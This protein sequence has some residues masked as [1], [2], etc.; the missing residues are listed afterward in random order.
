MAITAACVRTW[1]FF[2]PKSDDLS[3]AR[4]YHNRPYVLLQRHHAY[5]GRDNESQAGRADETEQPPA[6][7]I[8]S[9]VQRTIKVSGGHSLEHDHSERVIAETAAGSLFYGPDKTSRGWREIGSP[10]REIV[11]FA[12]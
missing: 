10:R 2:D 8:H 9:V 5:L 11:K 7:G 6:R 4:G 1:L 3:I 12:A